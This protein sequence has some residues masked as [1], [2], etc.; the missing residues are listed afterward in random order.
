MEKT[1]T[2]QIEEFKA[3][4]VDTINTANLHPYILDSIVGNIYNEVHI[5]YQNQV[6][7]EKEAYE[8]AMAKPE[9][10]SDDDVEIVE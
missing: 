3:K 2:I 8:K 4:L 5:L 10:I 7:Y 9:K 1:L 6:K